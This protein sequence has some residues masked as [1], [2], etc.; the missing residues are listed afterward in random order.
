MIIKVNY[1]VVIRNVGVMF[2]KISVKVGEYLKA[3][4]YI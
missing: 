2:A 3:V 4:I 1:G